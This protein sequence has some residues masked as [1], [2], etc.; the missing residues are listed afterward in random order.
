[1]YVGIKDGLGVGL[2]AM[3]VGKELGKGVGLFSL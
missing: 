1:L 3:Y 2:K